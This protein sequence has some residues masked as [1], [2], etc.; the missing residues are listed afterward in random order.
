MLV[1]NRS[2]SAILTLG[3]D[4]LSGYKW[5]ML[6]HKKWSNHIHVRAHMYSHT[7]TCMHIVWGPD[8]WHSAVS[9]AKCIYQTCS[10]CLCR[11][12]MLI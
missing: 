5:N 2:V 8:D 7:H 10:D 9:L 1:T 12:F 11:L 3:S 4:P 6:M